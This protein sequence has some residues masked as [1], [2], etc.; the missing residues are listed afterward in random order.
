VHVLVFI[1]YYTDKL[2]ITFLF[3]DYSKGLKLLQCSFKKILC[4][5]NMIVTWGSPDRKL[6]SRN[7][8][9]VKGK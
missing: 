1:N 9:K 7:I 6:Q 5:P 8:S 3:T 2:S 4:A